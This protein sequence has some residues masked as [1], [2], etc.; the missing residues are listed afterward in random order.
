MLSR[1]AVHDKQRYPVTLWPATPLPPVP[2]T[3]WAPLSGTDGQLDWR[4]PLE[5]AELPQEWVLRGL[6]DADLDDDDAVLA[7]L[8]EHGTIS[9]PYFDPAS[10]PQDRR[11]L[12]G[13]LPTEDE[14]RS[15]RWW[16]QRD[17]G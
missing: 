6:G 7:L 2:V 15:G 8:G 16:Q 14:Q 1:M 4:G 13:H 12:L 9:W 10:L 5:P 3:R 11:P 17:D